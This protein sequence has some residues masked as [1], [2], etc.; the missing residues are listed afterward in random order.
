M[1]IRV[2]AAAAAAA[3]AVSLAA[4]SGTSAGTANTAAASN[5]T[6][7]LLRVGLNLNVTDLDE[8]KTIGAG[9]VTNMALET[10]EKFGPQGQL[11]PDLATSFS[12]TS[13]VTY[14]YHLRHDATFWD[15][16][17]VTAT[18]V[19]Y[20]LNYDR[21]PGSQV[22]FSFAGVKSI[23]ATDKY[24][25]TV[26]LTQPEASWQYVPAELTS[27]VFEAAFQQAHKATYGQPGTLVMGS[28]PWIINSFDP[29]KG[30]MM[31]A[32]PHWWGG[33]VP[34][35]RV[36]FTFYSSETS[37]ALALRAGE[38]D[39]D[40]SITSPK[41]F[42]A[43][44]G[45]TLLTTPDCANDWF[46]MNTSQPGWNDVHV[47]RAVAY[48]LNRTDIIAAYG[49]YA[50]PIYTFTPPSLLRS[51]ASPP[52]VNALLASL[53]LYQYNLA[54]AKQQM[55]ESAYPNGFTST[56]AMYN[57]GTIP[58]VNQVIAAELAKIGIKLQLKSMPVTPW[59]G[60]ESGPAAQRSTVF[61]SGGCFQPDPGTY[62]DFLGR[63]NLATGSWNIANYAPPA[64]DTLLAQGQATTNPAQRF[65][66]YSKLWARLQSDVP[67]VGLFVS[68][69][70]AALSPKFTWPDFN[71]WYWEGDY[72]LD[73]RAAA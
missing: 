7:P 61:A 2:T 71:P 64:V 70:V 25:V 35:Q 63:D 8:T 16:H 50:T 73:I 44:S 1:K 37:E 45:A 20:S 68:D 28:G 19:A 49:G 5:A 34:I 23:V 38:I 42:A 10:L 55:A 29:T 54:K 58:D 30:A 72:L 27:Y 6:I 4:C 65:A 21:A 60:V 40:P 17:P 3:L 52:Q 66:T 53:P 69:R 26:T 43:A 14:V 15:G 41:S 46:G 24:T 18:D 9:N 47:R 67:Y 11:E 59:Q 31:T 48:A 33:K 12:Q 39:F 36:E 51:V 22:A 56:I 32:N 62:A 13:P 57:S